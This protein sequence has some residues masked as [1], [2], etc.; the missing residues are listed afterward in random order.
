M[1]NAIRVLNINPMIA[2]CFE[3]SDSVLDANICIHTGVQLALMPLMFRFN[4]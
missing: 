3:F 2:S 4:Q 1:Q